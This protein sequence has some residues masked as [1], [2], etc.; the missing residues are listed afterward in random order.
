M[1]DAAMLDAGT[2]DAAML[3]AGMPD[4]GTPG[5]GTP[6][7]MIDAAMP[8]AG[9]PDAAVPDAGMPD[10][11]MPDAGTPPSDGPV[12]SQT[13][14]FTCLGD[15]CPWGDSV[16]TEALVWPA[17]EGTVNTQLGYLVSAGIYLP[18]ARANGTDI[19]IET[20]EATVYWGF[21]DEEALRVLATLEAGD[22][23]HVDGIPDDS[24]LSVQADA[25]FT[26]RIAL[27][28]SSDPGPA[29]AE[30]IPSTQAFWRCNL[31]GCMFPDWTGAVI[32]WPS[33]A[34]YQTNA[35]SGDQSRSVF[36]GD[37]MPLYPYMGSWA[38]GCE[39]TAESGVALIIEWQRGTDVW[40][41][42]WLYPRMSHVIDLVPPEDGAMIETY[43]GSPGFSVSVKNCTPQPISP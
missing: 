17:A 30:A 41:E 23:F 25:P 39:V 38:Q 14:A 27:S 32:G 6:D 37:G 24:V 4:A 36:S 22:A 5:S 10:A 13:V 29:P 18:G 43:D 19:S 40:R 7:A 21:P 3:D 2:L 1:L 35:R 16:S 26:Y 42:T 28:P 33:W 12:A 8:D 31:P 11:G 9:T 20:G 34:A 15:P